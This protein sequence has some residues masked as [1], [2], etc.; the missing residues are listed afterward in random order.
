MSFAQ[1]ENYYFYIYD[2]I[3]WGKK[4]KNSVIYHFSLARSLTLDLS[5]LLLLLLLLLSS[6]LSDATWLNRRRPG[7]LFSII[8]PPPP[9][10]CAS[11]QARR[12]LFLRS[13]SR[14]FCF[15]HVDDV[16]ALSNDGQKGRGGKGQG[17]PGKCKGKSKG[18]DKGKDKGKG[19]KSEVGSTYANPGRPKCFQPTQEDR[20]WTSNIAQGMDGHRGGLPCTFRLPKAWM[21]TGGFAM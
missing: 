7:S 13:R 16:E 6:V 19:S 8:N 5:L 1:K 3:T 4:E 15:F 20:Q 12:K 10:P 21:D 14:V 17:K 18:K 9:P 11:N 2:V